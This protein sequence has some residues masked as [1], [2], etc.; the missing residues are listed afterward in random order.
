M[1]SKSKKD[2]ALQFLDDLDSFTPVEAPTGSGPTASAPKNAPSSK[3]K[4]AAKP[5][6]EAE[7]LAFIDEMTQ[8]SNEPSSR[9]TA[10]PP[11]RVGTPN[12]RKSTERVRLGGGP[13]GSNP[14]AAS[15]TASLSMSR[16]ASTDPASKGPAAGQG[17]TSSPP[18]P[19]STS[20][21]GAPAGG[22]GWNSVW[23]TAS[24][25]IQQAK[26]VVDEQVKHIPQNEKV[27]NWGEGVIEYAKNAQLDKLSQDFKRVGLSTL[28]D[29]LNV[30]APPIAEHEVIQ[31]WLS[32]DMQGYE[33]VDTV[34]YRS[35]SKV[36]EQV[37]G[38]DLIVNRGDESKPKEDGSGVRELNAVEGD[39][40]ALK[41]AEVNVQS[42]VKR[43]VK[44]DSKES[45]INTPTTY[46]NVYLRIQPFYT[47]P[48]QPSLVESSDDP[49]QK[50]QFLI[51]LY[52]PEH[53]LAFTSVTQ[54]V[55]SQWLSIWDEYDWVEDL[56]ADALRLGVEVIGQDYLVSRMGWG[57]SN[58]E[59]SEEDEE[60][61]EEA[62]KKEES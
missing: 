18:L 55:S 38:G 56:V 9:L 36:M 40:A 7:V 1:T 13:V 28:T 44:L 51:Y 23:S 14:S 10:Q 5:G 50:I 53:K 60:P 34:V 26:S 41:L 59:S 45:N 22:W 21:G 35:M 17:S 11:A 61:S 32:H 12:L 30:V 3:S 16:S 43:N 31:I 39:E 25:A 42:M 6:Q 49:S 52:D 4:Q 20:G 27:R 8:K 37:K 58:S 29:I 15:S 19:A 48:A 2:E 47:S 54:G 33:G 62:R 46:S 57:S 24:A